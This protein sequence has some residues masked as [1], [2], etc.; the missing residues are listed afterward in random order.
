MSKNCANP[1]LVPKLTADSRV[2]KNL[3]KA[4]LSILERKH[5]ITLEKRDLE[6]C[7]TTNILEKIVG[8]RQKVALLT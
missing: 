1:L 4:R 8:T 3:A 5:Y 2:R 7:K 6:S